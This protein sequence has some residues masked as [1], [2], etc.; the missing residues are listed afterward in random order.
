MTEH[1]KRFK[2]NP[3]LE[4]IS[5]NRWESRRVYNAAAILLDKKIHLLYRAECNDNVS[6][7]GYAS[8]YDGY[9]IDERLDYPILE[10]VLD[11]EQ[12]GC[13]DPRISVIDDRCYLN[14]TA[15]KEVGNQLIYQVSLT[16]IS[17]NDFLKKDWNWGKRSL[18]FEGIRNKNAALFP[19]K[20]KGRYLMFHRIEPDVCL[21][22]S[23]DLE[24]WYGLKALMRP[25]QK[26]WDSLKVGCTG[27]PIELNEG[28][29]FIY[30]GV[31]Y[32]NV[33][34][35]G[36]ALLDKS[37]PEQILFRKKN[38]ILEPKEDYELFGKVPNVVFSCGNI[39][40]D[41]KVLV[42]YGGADTVL[43]VATFELGELLPKQ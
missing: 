34:R 38:P 17:V 5:S 29:L 10:P 18:P 33:Y 24:R 4:S 42:Y 41:D 39:L 16:S 21:A 8:T 2:G 1:M 7:L 30:H 20:I 25:R 13:E 36:V 27:P 26:S 35:L 22:S 12:Y 31:D 43:C 28:W 6:R 32:H 15:V 19:K 14:Y 9:N 11:E 40:L 3:I 37:D 23:D